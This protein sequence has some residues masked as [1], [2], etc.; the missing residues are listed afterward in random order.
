MLMDVLEE[1][2]DEA[3]FQWLLWERALLA[4]NYNLLETVELEERMLAHLDGLLEGGA[5]SVEM[6]L[7]PALDS[8]ESIRVSAASFAL[9]AGGAVGWETVLAKLQTDPTSQHAAIQRA[10]ELSENQQLSDW[11]LPL[12]KTAD[13][14][15]QATA[16]EA[17]VFRGEAPSELPRSILVSDEPRLKMAL[18]SGGAPLPVNIRRELAL[19]SLA[20]PH[21]GVRDAALEAGLLCGLR[22]SWNACRQIVES[23]HPDSREAMILLALG[24]EEKDA[25]LLVEH[26]ERPELRAQALWALGIS[27]QLLSAEACLEYMSDAELGPLAGEAFSVITGLQ[28]QGP[29]VLPAETHDQEEPVPL[30]EENLDDNLDPRPEDFLPRPNALAIADWWKKNQGSFQRR[31]RY[32]NGRPCDAEALLEALRHGPMRRRHVVA[33]ELAIRTRGSCL[34]PVRALTRRQRVAMERAAAMHEG[35]SMLPLARTLG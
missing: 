25:M 17:L 16:L 13:P 26:L 5:P 11:L 15:L 9:L 7:K 12:L 18:L 35:I 4:P 10:L 14:A 2:M 20:S 24:G 23:G 31:I 1:H 19:Q 34:V 32:L 6:L 3:A 21:A 27:G 33:R 30:E 8:K 28:L 29:Y 22:I